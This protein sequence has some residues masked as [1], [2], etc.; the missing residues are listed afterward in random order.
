MLRADALL[1]LQASNCNEQIPAK[2][3]EY[4][5][6]G[7]PIVALTDPAGDTAGV[8]RAAGL[9]A[10]ARLDS[11]DDTVALLRRFIASVRGGGSAV[12]ERRTTSRRRRDAAAR[13]S[14]RRCS[15]RRCK[16]A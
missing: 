3:Y 5:R 14:S 16:A 11:V 7:R 12:A 4:L 6:A 8:V 9:D 10:I 1:V 13:G 15:M 2:L